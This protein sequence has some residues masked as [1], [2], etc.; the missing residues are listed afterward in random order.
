MGKK[1]MGK[2]KKFVTK[3]TIRW[4]I[5]DTI[6]L[7]L[8]FIHSTG[9]IILNIDQ[10]ID[11]LIDYPVVIIPFFI[12]AIILTSLPYLIV[13]YALRYAI[14]KYNK[15]VV[16]FDVEYDLEYYREKFNGISPATMSLLMDLNLE[17][18]KDVGSMKLYYELHDIYMYV[19]DGQICLNNPKGIKINKSDE[20]LLKYF[21]DNKNKYG[22]KANWFN[23]AR[24]FQ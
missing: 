7:T 19:H 21:F 5:V 13:Y 9:G 11:M 17:T 24:I 6:I 22:Q 20:I 1:K 15:S 12:F 4:K 18:D 14:K 2:K 3:K 10:W 23:A 8:I 16:T